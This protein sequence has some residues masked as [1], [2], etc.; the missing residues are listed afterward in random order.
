[1][2]D[3]P[4][5][6]AAP[7]R[8]APAP[9]VAI[10]L[11]YFMVILDV[12]IVNVAAPA[13]GRDLQASV[14]GV[15][16]VVDGYSIAFAGLLLTGGAL[17]DRFGQRR[18][19]LTGV[20]LFTAA[21]FGCMVA[22]DIVLL[23]VFRLLE[24]TGSALL[25]P[26][27][28]ALLQQAYPSP[29]LRAR[30]FGLWGSIAGSAATAGPLIGGLLTSTVGWR[31]AFGINLP[32]GVLCVALTLRYVGTA[33]ERTPRPIDWT[34]QVAVVVA[35]AGFIGA[36]NEL[37]RDGPASP[38]VLG[39]V[40]TGLVGAAV[41][42]VRQRTSRTPAIPP[43]M[44]RSPAFSGGTVIG[45]VFNFGFYGMIFAASVFFQQHDGLSPAVAG[46]ALLPAVAVTMVASTL[47]GRMA[48]R[49]GH[50]RLMLV[51][52]GVAAAGLA[53]WA[54]AG[55][56]PP[57]LVLAV[58]MVACGF[59]T[60]FTL[61]GATATVMG[62][63]TG[64]YAGTASAA[65]NTTRQTGSAAGVAVSGSLVAALGLGTGIPAFMAIGATGYLVGVLLTARCVP[66][67]V[68]EG[69]TAPT[70]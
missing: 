5:A 34:S 55:G 35:V 51:G 65:L 24:G 30:A 66:R 49:Y 48:A 61:T 43:S 38:L 31:W 56:A 15:Q 2:S 3:R 50:R 33:G 69:S 62:S 18:L 58:A 32:V 17:G 9:L 45:F 44:M 19:F 11:G 6:S 36:L 27:T 37:G 46:L 7:G 25:V 28:L 57:Y 23:T 67:R 21:S 14:T 68:E 8:L 47:S 40:G 41:F 1:M 70:G 63:A 10:C 13:I 39:L 53:V 26:S 22:G 4:D 29:G 42:A 54:V 16:W 64:G 12:T 52:L 60:S 20:G 59:G